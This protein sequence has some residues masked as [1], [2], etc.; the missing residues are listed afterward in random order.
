MDNQWRSIPNRIALAVLTLLASA[1]FA[2]LLAPPAALACAPA[3]PDGPVESS[4][5]RAPEDPCA[6]R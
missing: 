1:S 4:I 2:G 6:S 3:S 5:H